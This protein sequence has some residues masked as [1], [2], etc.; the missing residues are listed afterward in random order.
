MS[1]LPKPSPAPWLLVEKRFVP[2]HLA[3]YESVFALANGYAGVR[4]SLPTNLSLGDP[5]FF[6]AGVFDRLG[7][8]VLEHEIVNLPGW[9]GLGLNVN[10]FEIDLRKGR[11]LA[12]RRVL[13]LRQGILFTHLVWRDAGQ[14]TTRLDLAQLLHLEDKHV[15]L[16]W[17]TLTPLDYSAQVQFRGTLDGWS[18]K[19]GS[20]SGAP[21]LGELATADLG[22]AGGIA[23]QCRTRLTGIQVAL[24]ARLQAAGATARH[25]RLSDDRAAEVVSARVEKGQPLAFEKRVAI[26]T[27]RDGAD[28]AAAAQA[29]LARLAAEPLAALVARHTR[30]WGRVWDA[31]DIRIDGDPR[32]QKALRF[33]I[34]HLA[35]LANAA[36][37][38][39][40]LGAKGLH[41]TG[42]Q[43]LVFWDTEI[44]LLPFYIHTDPA[45]ARALLRYRHHF[46][47]DARANACALG[48]PGA[49]YPW[50]SSLSGRQ[51]HWKGWQEHVGSDV[52]YG[53]DWYVQASGDGA[54]FQECGV[55]VLLETA[56]YW[57]A[58]VELDPAR[59]QYVIRGL[60]GPDELHGGIDNNTFTN[61]LVKW[62]LARA[63]AAV[64][65]LEAAGRWAPLAQ[66][67][68]I[69]A[70]D[71]A[72]WDDISRRM[73]LRFNPELN[74]H[75][76]FD[77]YMNLAEKAI[78]RRLSRMQYT[79]PVQHSFKPTKVAQQADTVLMYYMF[80]HAFD[81]AVRRAGY[82]YYDPRC[83]HTSSLSRCIFAAVAAQAGLLQEAYRQFMLSAENDIAPG[84]EMES[85]SGIHAACMGGTWLAAVTGFG[86]V[87]PHAGRLDLNPVLAPKWKALAF[88]VKWHG[89]T[90]AVEVTRRAL[91]LRA[92]G[93]RVPVRV[94]ERDLTVGARTVTLSR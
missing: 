92:S 58:R 90:L 48:R 79:G 81:R 10:G 43:G 15:G 22:P 62:H 39:V 1:Q 34:F 29:E 91:R 20:P 44:F 77:G 5:G 51:N 52:A 56:R 59:Q 89:A 82:L 66:R 40:S 3:H 49:F 63:V 65:E 76:Q 60:M 4:A 64:R 94:G 75:E 72:A 6:V 54:F 88:K 45:A 85:E 73:F 61:Q 57:Q 30:A 23:L 86:G 47:D 70:A 25:V 87:W 21:R 9:L 80:P 37:D 83:S 32:A 55:E 36:D 67:L 38:R 24:A 2:G 46:L 14:Q 17:G 18:V 12:Y 7:A 35:S 11:L 68:G 26:F 69:A 71:V 74:I 33:N 50:N 42:Y 93:G 8:E 31:A 78:N 53:I 84:C 27:S 19:Y 28:P 13:D 16:L 41:G